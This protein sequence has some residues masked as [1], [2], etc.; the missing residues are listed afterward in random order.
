LRPELQRSWNL[1]AMTKP[2][3]ELA[4]KEG[5]F[6]V[7]WTLTET[8]QI[9][10]AVNLEHAALGFT[11]INPEQNEVLRAIVEHA[12]LE[13]TGSRDM[14]LDLYAGD[15]NLSRRLAP[16]FERTV[17]VES[18]GPGR[19]PEKLFQQLE[20]TEGGDLLSKLEGGVT[21]VS[22]EV[23]AF[24]RSPRFKNIKPNA[25]IADPPREGLL[26]TAALIAQRHAPTVVLVSCDPSTLARDLAAFT[27]TYK[28]QRLHLV[29]MFPQTFHL[30][31]VVALRR[32]DS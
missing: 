7:E 4:R 32:N 21:H 25:L 29:D 20:I 10:E 5:M 13:G 30:E 26:S 22:E 19:P 6:K 27:D 12:V 23:E 9:R 8:G 28:I 3:G 14:L 1:F 11:Q 24:L 31:A 17:C 15:G 18:H 16:R 2:L